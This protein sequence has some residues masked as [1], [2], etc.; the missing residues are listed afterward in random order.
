[1]NTNAP[2][3]TRHCTRPLIA[4]GVSALF[5]GI[6]PTSHAS[7]IDECE[8]DETM[9]E[10][11]HCAKHRIES[12]LAFD[13]EELESRTYYVAIS[14]ADYA[15]QTGSES[16]ECAFGLTSTG[17]CP[18]GDDAN[19]GLSQHRPFATYYQA[20][21]AMH[22][23]SETELGGVNVHFTLMIRGGDFTY[24]EPLL[25]QG[26][27]NKDNWDGEPVVG[28]HLFDD[29]GSPIK[30]DADGQWLYD[31][32]SGYES[33]TPIVANLSVQPFE[34][35]AVVFEGLCTYSYHEGDSRGSSD[36]SNNRYEMVQTCGEETSSLE[37]F[38]KY[39]GSFESAWGL[40]QINGG[41][42]IDIEDLTV[43]NAS[44]FGIR[45]Q[46]NT[47]S[48]RLRGVS[49][50]ETGYSGLFLGYGVNDVWV[51][52][53]TFERACA[54]TNQE[55]VTFAQD[56]TN[57]GFANNSILDGYNDASLDVKNGSHNI[58]IFGNTFSGNVGD[59]IYIDGAHDGVSRVLIDSNS[60]DSGYYARALS[61]SS[62]NGGPVSEIRVVNNI[63][64]NQTYGFW[65]SSDD[66]NPLL[67]DIQFLFNTVY[68][69]GNAELLDDETGED[70]NGVGLV[71]YGF[72]ISHG[73]LED[74]VIANNIFAENHNNQF[75][76]NTDEIYVDGTDGTLD[77]DKIRI[78][79]NIV[80][81]GDDTDD[82]D[83]GYMDCLSASDETL[84][85]FNILQADPE[86]VDP[87]LGD[88]GLQSSSPALEQAVTL[89][90]DAPRLD[91]T[92]RFRGASKS[93]GA[94]ER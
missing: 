35:E 25:I 21:K 77:T 45:M 72:R 51:E 7:F 9:Y 62:E 65:L 48:V 82:D 84:G 93:I 33:A 68:N 34:E 26:E 22:D 4:L 63:S 79:N 49:T 66:T 18:W 80:W 50:V 24:R 23:Y 11:P 86:F 3:P 29:A 74:V 71:G 73:N 43:Q 87:E 90:F 17:D 15:N 59:D 46:T 40:I 57:I 92:G 31:G 13:G 14:E 64:T 44:A 60:F 75:R 16:P 20:F 76:I 5:M 1:M 30:L 70:P 78:A 8:G 6:I 53:S 10:A 89:G 37:G 91:Y 56:A 47:D 67:S 41:Y 42:R 58:Y 55:N 85:Q 69:A 81:C 28:P 27:G 19:D 52:D 54:L 2:H 94:M 12:A 39:Y 61:I 83:D 32:D 36:W 38:S 88:F